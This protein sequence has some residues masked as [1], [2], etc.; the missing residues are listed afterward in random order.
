VLIQMAV[1][2]VFR[3][4]KRT[5]ITVLA[6]FWGVL[7]S[8]VANGVNKGMEW[9]MGNMFI[10]TD[11]SSLKIVSQDYNLEDLEN[12][13]DYP[14]KE[15]GKILPILK[16]TPNV[17]AYSP[18]IAFHSS[19]SNGSDEIRA[20]G[21]GVDPRMEDQVFNRSQGIVQG[22]YL[23][24]DEEGIVIGKDL[25]KLLGLKPGDSV[26][27]ISQAAQMG[28]NAYDLEIKGLIETGN[29][30]LDTGGFWV[31]LK[32]AREFLSFTGVTDIA[33]ALRNNSRIDAFKQQFGKQRFPD[34]VK[35]ASWRDYASDYIEL[36][37]F[38]GR[39]I[40]VLMV[41]I[42]LMAAAGIMN[43]MLMA[44]M[45]RK[46]EIGNLMALGVRRGE[47]VRL[48]LIEGA[49]IGILGS[50]VAVVLGSSIVGYFQWQGI[51]LGVDFMSNMGSVP[52]AGK[53]YAYLEP[54][55][56]LLYFLMGIGVAVISAVY[57][58][59]KSARM[60][61]VDAIRGTGGDK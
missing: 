36:V 44:M 4:R 55:E 27:V 42:L 29:P 40:S 10:K 14:I 45:E 31:P 61:P 48:F 46:R 11:S 19:L 6:V 9:Q 52:I 57:P 32:F 58:A 13:L 59:L 25:A 33:V 56:V 51:P 50:V 60:Q 5:M 24:P 20:I 18:R 38:R 30:V 53:L 41:M 35:V 34:Q 37:E 8:I 12:P 2:N 28:M 23:A 49:M 7:L 3:N 17:K 39:I 26:T 21:L 43:T 22:H 47:I 16:D 54:F 1:K 15:D